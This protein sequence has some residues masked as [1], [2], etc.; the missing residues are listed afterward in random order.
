MSVYNLVVAK[1]G[2]KFKPAETE[3]VDELKLKHPSGGRVTGGGLAVRG[4]NGTQFYG[5]Y[6][7]VAVANDATER[8]GQ[9]SSGQDRLDRGYDFTLPAAAEPPQPNGA[10]PRRRIDLH[11]AAEGAGVA[12]GASEGHR[13]ET[14]VI[15]HVERPTEN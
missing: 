8:C 6:D 10:A 1:G 5:I 11:G 7:G 2:P 9:T 3:D 12:A 13:S 14:L 4:P 15:D